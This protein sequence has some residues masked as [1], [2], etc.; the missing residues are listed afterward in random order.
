MGSTKKS[1]EVKPEGS[2]KYSEEI[3]CY[4]RRK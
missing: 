3:D 2:D 1:N 4:K